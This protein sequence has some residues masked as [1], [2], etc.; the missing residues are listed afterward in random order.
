MYC[1]NFVEDF[2]SKIIDK[3]KCPCS[4]KNYTHSYCYDDFEF[5][6]CYTCKIIV[7]KI[8]Y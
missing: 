3:M 1:S 5:H 7:V 2:A 4:I 8:G 6:C